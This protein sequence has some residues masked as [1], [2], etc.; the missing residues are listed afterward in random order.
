MLNGATE[1]SLRDYL[2]KVRGTRQEIV[3]HWRIRRKSE[4]VPSLDLKM[5]REG[6][7]PRMERGSCDCPRGLLGR[8]CDLW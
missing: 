5:Q 2:Q 7:V 1:E 4:M 6:E 3:H 8:S